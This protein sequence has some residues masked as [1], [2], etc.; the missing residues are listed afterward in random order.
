MQKETFEDMRDLGKKMNP[1]KIRL[2]IYD[3]HLNKDKISCLKSWVEESR[4]A[5]F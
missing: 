5:E 2:E 3:N 1:K 4:T